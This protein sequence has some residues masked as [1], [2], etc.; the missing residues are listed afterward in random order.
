MQYKTVNFS[1]MISLAVCFDKC[2]YFRKYVTD[3]HNFSYM[4]YLSFSQ[5]GEPKQKF[6][7]K[8]FILQYL[9]FTYACTFKY[10]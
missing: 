4:M 8:Q 1:L 7:N 10:S 3:T 9:D 5:K 2:Q 6:K